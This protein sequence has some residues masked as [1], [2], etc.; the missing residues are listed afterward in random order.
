MIKELFVLTRKKIFKYLII[1][2][3]L[4]VGISLKPINI[5][6]EYDNFYNKYSNNL[7]L[8]DKENIWAFLP[9]CEEREYLHNQIE[10]LIQRTEEIQLYVDM[11]EKK[12]NSSLFKDDVNKIK[13]E[14]AYQNGRLNADV[15]FEDTYVNDKVL[16]NYLSVYGLYI[17]SVILILSFFYDDIKN[18][19]LQIF[20]TYKNNLKNLFLSKL[21]TYLGLVGLCTIVFMLT[22]ML[23]IEG[24]YSV[25]NL[26]SLRETFINLDLIGYV[27]A[28]YSNAFV[29]SILF[30]ILLMT[31]L[32]VIRNLVVTMTG[33]FLGMLTSFFAF[34]SIM[35]NLK[36]FNLYF[37][38]FVDKLQYNG[39]NNVLNITK[40]GL[41]ILFVILFYVIYVKDFSIDI[42]KKSKKVVLKTTNSIIHI[43]R[44]LLIP[45]KGILAI[46]VV[47]LFSIYQYNT[48]KM[49]FDYKEVSYQEFKKQY[50]GPI[51]EERY[52]EILDDQN[53]IQECYEKSIIIWDLI[54]KNPENSAELLMENEE[55]LNE[56]RDLENIGRLRTEFEEAKELGL[57]NLVDNRGANLLVMKEKEIYFIEFICILAIPLIFVYMSFRKQMIL[58]SYSTV[59][60]T[61]KTGEKKYL[62]FSNGLFVL[63]TIFNTIIMIVGH[64]FKIEKFYPLNLSYTLKDLLFANVGLSLLTTLVI[65]CVVVV[66][67]IVLIS[68]FLY[69]IIENIHLA[70]FDQK[71]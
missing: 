52:Q 17:I 40:L 12:A 59:I 37:Y 24:N 20:K 18:G 62:L 56:A 3:I 9:E 70:K 25:Y 58:P 49:S 53:E 48:F 41:C 23:Q 61:S 30:S 28:K 60:K 31:I 50:L 5:S 67:G 65:F 13:H 27:V 39:L 42:F 8:I 36:Y 69:S 38:M 32:L 15:K 45:S 11:A 66:L 47:L 6:S 63:L 1:L 19:Q 35:S 71:N 34:G 14:L 2:I 16:S 43:L 26:E 57:D 21:L 46:A 54:D 51:N 44:E 29:N 55:I 68:K 10:Y 64:I 33:L 7:D 4:C 22:E